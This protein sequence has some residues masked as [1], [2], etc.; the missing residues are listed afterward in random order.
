ML[1]YKSWLDTRWRFLIGLAILIVVAAGTV[2]DYL[3]VVRVMPTARTIDAGGELGRRIKDALE[4]QRDYRGFIW[5]Q[6]FRQNLTQIGTLF[7]VL[8]GSGGLLSRGWGG[9]PLFM[10]SL[11][12]SR[13]QLF[14]VRAATG[15]VE[16]LVLVLVPT[17]LLALL[18]PAI[19]QS[20]A[21]GE[22]LVHI[23]CLFITAAAFFSLTFLLSTLF[24]DPWRPLLIGCLAAV[25]LA[26]AELT[27]PDFSSYG[28]FRVMSGEAY[29]RSG[30][31]PWAGLLASLGLSAVMLLTAARNVARQDF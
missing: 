13:N 24:N 10:L 30:Q 28:I 5:W 16:L 18:S 9:A 27:V 15:L 7:A 14:G 2:F 3:A 17:L 11:P 31:L 21:L 4:I 29:F 8:L 1:W 23:V 26:A 12:A 19:G 22:A 25:L 6:W 20:Y